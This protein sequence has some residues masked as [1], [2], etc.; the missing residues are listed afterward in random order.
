MAIAIVIRLTQDKLTIVGIV[1]EVEPV[2][3]ILHERRLQNLQP[4]RAGVHAGN[5][6]VGLARGILGY[7]FCA[8]APV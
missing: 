6:D 4:C 5:N 8:G 7:K 3:A 2:F 1:P